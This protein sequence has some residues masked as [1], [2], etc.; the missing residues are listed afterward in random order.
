VANLVGSL[1]VLLS[2]LFGGFLLSRKQ[3]PPVVG[4]LARLSFVRCGPLFLASTA[5]PC[6]TACAAAEGLQW[7]V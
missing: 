4:W 1:A 7:E 5:P 2:T 6:S 3:M